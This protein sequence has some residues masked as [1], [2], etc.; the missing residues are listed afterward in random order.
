MKRK[1]HSSLKMKIQSIKDLCEE[2]DVHKLYFFGSSVNGN[3]IE[4]KSDLD[5]YLE[6]DKRNYPRIA[7]F[8]Y[9]LK[10]IVNIEIDIFSEHWV[11]NEELS[12]YIHEN[13]VLIYQKDSD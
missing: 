5:I 4:G 8:G 6:I 10:K 3:F 2:F 13:K 11:L 7:L 12:N 1:I 9:E